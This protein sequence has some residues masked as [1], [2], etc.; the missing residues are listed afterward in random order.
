MGFP[1]PWR[2]KRERRRGCRLREAGRV[3]IK[4]YLKNY[5]GGCIPLI[6]SNSEHQTFAR[7][8]HFDIAGRKR[9]MLLPFMAVPVTTG[10]PV[11]TGISCAKGWQ[12]HPFSLIVGAESPTSSCEP[13]YLH[14]TSFGVVAMAVSGHLFSGWLSGPL[15]SDKPL[16]LTARTFGTQRL[17]AHRSVNH[18]TNHCSR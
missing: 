3:G 8:F 9:Q 11:T 6:S 13:S 12:R 1:W 7:R 16:I 2:K 5:V 14:S 15:P 10:S 17:Y 4:I 18:P